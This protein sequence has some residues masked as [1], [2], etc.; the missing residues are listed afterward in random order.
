MTDR[1]KVTKNI[2][3]KIVGDL[4]FCLECAPLP[5]Y[6]SL[7][8]AKNV[9]TKENETFRKALKAK[10]WCNKKNCKVGNDKTEEISREQIIDILDNT[11][12]Y[13]H[14]ARTVDGLKEA[15]IEILKLLKENP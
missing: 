2:G 12:Y 4:C 8:H 6:E 14:D 3:V 15:A 5:K 9:A 11:I 13:N 7:E 1:N 10:Y